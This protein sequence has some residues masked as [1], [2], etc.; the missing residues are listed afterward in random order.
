MRVLAQALLTLLTLGAAPSVLAAPPRASAGDVKPKLPEVELGDEA[1]LASVV[2]LYEAG[3]YAECAGDLSRLLA[4]DEKNRLREREVIETARIYQAACLIGSGK[5]EA[6]DEPLRAAIRSN[7]QMRPPDSLVFPPPVIDRFLRVRQSLYDEIKKAEDQ[8]VDQARKAAE[9]QAERERA[10]NERVAALE[11]LA[12]SETVIIRNRRWI[13]WVPFGVGQFQNG[14][15]G[16]GWVFLTGETA[17]AATALTSLGMQSYLEVEANRLKN[18]DNNAVLRT[19]NTLLHVSSYAFL[20]VAA[21]GVAQAHVAFVPQVEQQR[22]RP[23]PPQLR[24][25]K[26]VELSPTLAAGSNELF[27]GVSGRF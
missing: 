13:A 3:K 6:A 5:P 12:T 7:M 26:A 4:P 18:P 17:L 2:S 20:G 23:L 27:L 9:I 25:A 11:R 8:R 24:R 1:K 19:W 16:L 14:N 10:E 22:Y 21:L 15:E